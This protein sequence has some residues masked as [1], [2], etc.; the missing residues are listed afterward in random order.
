MRKKVIWNYK[1][2]LVNG[3]KLN[4]KLSNHTHSI[5]KLVKLTTSYTVSANST[6]T[7]E[8]IC[9]TYTGYTPIGVVSY[10]TSNG[11]I[12]P[13]KLE[14]SSSM[15]RIYTGLRS[16]A[17]SEKTATFYCIVLYVVNNYYTT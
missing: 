16:V 13:Y 2:L 17:T 11:N 3:W 14:A 5:I 7:I 1:E 9:P 8:L 12:Y 15:N 6:V 10:N 4:T